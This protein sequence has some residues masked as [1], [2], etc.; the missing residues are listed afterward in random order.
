MLT[1]LDTKIRNF[2]RITVLVVV[3]V[4]LLVGP[5]FGLRNIGL[6]EWRK[7]IVECGTVLVSFCTFKM[8]LVDGPVM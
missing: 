2:I 4:I 1:L 6:N 3:I 5:T 7:F 8:Y